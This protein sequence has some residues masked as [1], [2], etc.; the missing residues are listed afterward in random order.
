MTIHP[1]KQK[2]FGDF[3][4]Q[5][6]PTAIFEDP[7]AICKGSNEI[8]EALDSMEPVSIAPPKCINMKPQG[9]PSF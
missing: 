6:S 4:L 9:A 7:K 5:L 3:W 2:L 8:L 1:P